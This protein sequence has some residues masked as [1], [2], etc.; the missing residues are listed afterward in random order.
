MPLALTG[1][2]ALTPS[3]HFTE[4]PKGSL[5]A[6]HQG[7]K[8]RASQAEMMPLAILNLLSAFHFDSQQAW[9]LPSHADFSPL[10]IRP[11]LARTPERQA[12]VGGSLPQ[13]CQGL[14]GLRAVMTWI[15][16]GPQS[17]P[18]GSSL[19]PS[20]AGLLHSADLNPGT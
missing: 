7:S 1:G 13:P 16:L 18:Q 11:S 10:K 2:R 3:H 20:T 5:W 6:R 9:V 4:T 12:G 19:T 15:V 17:P 8:P 14:P